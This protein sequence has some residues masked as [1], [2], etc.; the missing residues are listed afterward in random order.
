MRRAALVFNPR[1]GQRKARRAL[2]EIRR[3]LEGAFELSLQPTEGPEHCRKIAR[4]A[5]AE[6]LDALFV[7]GGDGTLRVAAS[8]LAGSEVAIGP[9][10]G[11]TTNVVAGALG[12]PED[13][14][15]AARALLNAEPTLMDLGLAA[16]EPFLMQLSG[17]LDAQVM[18]NIN[19]RSKKFLG[20]GAIAIAGLREWF[21]Y[22]FPRFTLE[23]DGIAAHATGF[24]VANLPQYAGQFTIVPGARA[25]DRQLELLLY[26]GTRRRDALGFALALARGRHLERADV[27]VRCFQSLRLTAPAGLLLQAD[28]DAFVAP[29]PL[30]ITLAPERL[31]IL[32]PHA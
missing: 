2:P 16:G 4:Q 3:V 26:Q 13:P 27:S 23:I 6:R 17:G 7:L 15:A 28:G 8:V 29:A 5:L 11:G 24:V 20:K 30:T 32:A 31:R 18:A 21:R 9:L 12:L 14:V 22:R 19:L 10:P 25:D 1:A